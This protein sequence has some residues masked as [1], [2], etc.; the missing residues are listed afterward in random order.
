ML[1]SN[2]LFQ[3]FQQTLAN[4]MLVIKAILNY[5]YIQFQFEFHSIPILFHLCMFISTSHFKTFLPTLPYFRASF[6]SCIIIYF[7]STIIYVCIH[8]T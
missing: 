6:L 5:P 7:T 3:L 2:I 4:R 8:H 1:L